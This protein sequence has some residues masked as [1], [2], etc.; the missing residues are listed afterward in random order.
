MRVARHKA[1]ACRRVPCTGVSSTICRKPV[2]DLPVKVDTQRAGRADEAQWKWQTERWTQPRPK[3]H[4]DRGSCSP[5]YRG[6]VRPRA[7]TA[8]AKHLSYGVHLVIST[9]S[10][11]PSHT[12]HVRTWGPTSTSTACPHMHM[13]YMLYPILLHLV[14]SVG[15]LSKCICQVCYYGGT[16]PPSII[17]PVPPPPPAPLLFFCMIMLPLM[18]PLHS[19]SHTS[20]R[21]SGAGR[22]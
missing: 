12:I 8:R 7:A 5:P 3:P 16:M 18:C 13:C 2:A 10:F 14:L 6:E 15:S 20:G 17:M 22:T 9:C 19:P 1:L 4:R 11:S 21:A